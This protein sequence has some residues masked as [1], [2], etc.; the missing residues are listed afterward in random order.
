MNIAKRISSIAP[1]KP[2]IP[3]TIAVTIFRPIWN[4]HIP[5]IKFIINISIPPKTEFSISL[6][7][8][9]S[10]TAKILPIINNNN[11]HAK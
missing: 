8:A 11:I 2:N 5:P 9:F 1:G 10:G 6:N 3:T 7:K 4:P